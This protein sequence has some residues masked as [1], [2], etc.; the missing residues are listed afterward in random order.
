MEQMQKAMNQ[1]IQ[2]AKGVFQQTKDTKDRKELIS[3]LKKRQDKAQRRRE[4]DEA[5][6]RRTQAQ[7]LLKDE[8]QR[9]REE[10]ESQR[11]L[12][13]DEAQ[14]RR[15][16]GDDAKR[17]LKEAKEKKNWSPRVRRALSEFGGLEEEAYMAWCEEFG[18]VRGSRLLKTYLGVFGGLEEKA[19]MAWCEEFGVKA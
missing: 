3:E 7:R 17:L 8:A 4:E 1:V 6:R 11:R 10:D 12:E 13:E 14:R 2:Q 9:R 19:Y 16:R 18:M 5:Q 15:E